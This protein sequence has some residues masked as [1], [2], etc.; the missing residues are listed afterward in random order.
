MHPK[1]PFRLG[2]AG[3]PLGHSLSPHIHQLALRRLGLEGEYDLYPVAP[4]LESKRALAALLE[5][6]RRGDLHGL[7]VTI[8]YK[9]DILELI[10]ELSP[11]A[12]AIGAVNTL[13]A[14]D[15]YIA[16][17]NTDAHGFLAG[18]GAVFPQLFTG[19]GEKAALILGSGG[20]ARAVVFALLHSGW[21]VSVASRSLERAQRLADRFIKA[22][23]PDRVSAMQLDPHCIRAFMEKEEVALV[24][25]ATPAGMAPGIDLSPWPAEIPLP[26]K[27]AVYDLVYSPAETRFVKMAR[28]AGLQAH[29]GLG[30]LVEQAARAFEIWTGMKP[31]CEF[32]LKELR[33]EAAS[34]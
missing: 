7:N 12:S 19:G 21:Q 26:E 18:V 6:L 24:V 10:D 9:V 11:A 3:W 1:G 13:F 16:G 34:P 5:K 23:D 4:G 17:D 15:E 27:A 2:L 22:G 30:M 20:A 28:Q 29:T 33:K 25:N 32:I 8:P 14:R 31:S